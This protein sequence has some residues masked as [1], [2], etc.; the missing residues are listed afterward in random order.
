MIFVYIHVLW[1]KHLGSCD[2]LFKMPKKHLLLLV[3]LFLS[4]LCVFIPVYLYHSL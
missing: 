1:D 2:N 3:F 4:S